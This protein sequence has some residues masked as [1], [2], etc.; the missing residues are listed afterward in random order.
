MSQTLKNNRWLRVA[1]GTVMM[2]SLGTLYAWSIFRAPFGAAYPEWT[3]PDLSLNFTIS[4]VCYCIG[5]FLGGKLSKRTSNTVTACAAALLILVGFWGVS[6]LPSEPGRAKWMLY[7]F[8][9]VLSGL[10]T[11]L[12][13]NAI[14]SGVSGWFPDKTGLATGVMLTGF[15]LGTMVIGQLSNVLIPVL[16]LPVLFRVFAV[17]I[18]VIL[19]AGSPM[20]HL[21][22]PDAVRLRAPDGVQPEEQRS[23]TSGEMLRRPSF[24]I[25]FL[26]NMLMCSSGLL[27]INA[28]ANIASYYGAAAVLGLLLSVFNGLS[29]LPFGVLVDKFGRK[30]VM[31]LANCLLLVAGGLLTLGALSHS[32]PLVLAGMLVVGVCYGNSVTIGTLVIRQFYGSAHYATNLAIVNCC[33]V[34]ASFIG[35][36]I[37]SALQEAASGDYLTTFL[38]VLAFGVVDLLVGFC[39]RKP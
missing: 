11:G 6:M 35:P 39:V 8:Y 9:G 3:T 32:A 34:P 25:L 37:S 22:E 33:A 13:Y 17:T 15:G 5:G 21:P 10:G 31:L 4:M 23:Y 16:G 18:A 30:A 20:V 14:V 28:A 12:G 26:W 1:V 7:V 19:A 2:L 38:C 29:R 24:W 27:V 36:M